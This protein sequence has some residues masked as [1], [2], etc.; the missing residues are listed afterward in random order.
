MKKFLIIFASCLIAM[1]VFAPSVCSDE[2][3]ENVSELSVIINSGLAGGVGG[4]AG[5]VG[6]GST[7]GGGSDIRIA[8]Y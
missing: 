5:G 4:A 2:E 8:Q 7:G 3:S 1:A 6:G